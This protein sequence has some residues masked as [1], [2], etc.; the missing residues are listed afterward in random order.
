[1]EN[2][3]NEKTGKYFPVF[4][5]YCLKHPIF[6]HS[7]NTAS[8]SFMSATINEK[9]WFSIK[10]NC[11][12]CGK[13]AIKGPYSI[14]EMKMLA[15]MTARERNFDLA[16][17]WHCFLMLSEYPEKLE[18]PIMVGKYRQWRDTILANERKNAR[19]YDELWGK[20]RNALHQA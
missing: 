9:N 7:C 20:G 17:V 19:W 4:E 14:Q 1:M 3:L 6:C 12:S 18:N 11:H 8:G 5:L 13:V 15:R 10:I 16:Y 2:Q